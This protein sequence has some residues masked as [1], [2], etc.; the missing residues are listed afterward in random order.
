MDTMSVNVA[1][2]RSATSVAVA[3]ARNI[4]R[5]FLAGLVDPIPAEAAGACR[6]ARRRGPFPGHRGPQ[7]TAHARRHAPDGMRQVAD[8]GGRLAPDAARR[9]AHLARAA[10]DFPTAHATAET[11]G[12]PVRGHR[13]LGDIHFAHGNM[14]QAA[15][16]YAAAHTEAE[17]HGNLDEQ[18]ITQAHLA[19]TCAFA[20][21]DRADQEITHAEQLLAGLDQRATALTTQIAAL[22]RDAGTPGPAVDDRAA[23]MGTEITTAGITPAE[24]LLKLTLT[25][26]HTVRGDY[27]A[28]RIDIARLEELTRSGDYGP[29]GATIIAVEV[30]VADGLLATQAPIRPSGRA[31]RGSAGRPTCASQWRLTSWISADRY[32]WTMSRSSWSP[33]ICLLAQV[34]SKSMSGC[35]PNSFSNASEA[36]RHPG[37]V[38]S[39]S[40]YASTPGPVRD[41]IVTECS[42]RWIV[43][44]SPSFTR[45]CGVS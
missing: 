25:L 4:A 27:A 30:L 23:L 6:P 43:A 21:P 35:G 17:Q 19:L 40:A 13:V 3:V 42:P 24:L 20:D 10:D 41:R 34:R 8:A 11:L 12:R 1:I 16:A 18:A 36:A 37:A 22:A 26:H 31:G 38:H 39:A 32:S 2:L 7:P 44:L 33:A 5:D 15:T 14:D 9:L 29:G 45:L 28:V